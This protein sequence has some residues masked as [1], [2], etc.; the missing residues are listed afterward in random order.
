[1]SFGHVFFPLLL[2]EKVF[3]ALLIGLRLLRL[4]V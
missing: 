3:R 2:E 4:Y 1:M